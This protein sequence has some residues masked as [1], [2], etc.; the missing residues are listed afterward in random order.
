MKNLIGNILFASFFLCVFSAGAQ[1]G[2]SIDTIFSEYGRQKGSVLIN[3][4]KDVLAGNTKIE[5]YKCLMT[6]VPPEVENRIAESVRRD[7]HRE[8][9]AGN[10]FMLK[11]IRQDGMV[12]TLYFAFGVQNPT[13]EREYILYNVKDGKITL[14]YMK[15]KFPVTDWKDEL[16]KLK[17][18]FIKLNNK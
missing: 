11:E 5:R 13:A 10:T 1:Q 2:L 3:L 18:L 8:E 15:G 17:N 6:D 16:D 12:K 4:G 9:Q 7:F 14:I